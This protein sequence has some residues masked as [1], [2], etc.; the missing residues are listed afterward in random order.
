MLIISSSFR[1]KIT[2]PTKSQGGPDPIIRAR[3]DDNDGQTRS[4]PILSD[5]IFA[6]S[7]MSPI[8]AV[9]T[10][11]GE[12]E[13]P[14]EDKAQVEEQLKTPGTIRT[15]NGSVIRSSSHLVAIHTVIV[16]V[17]PS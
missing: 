11:S 6:I 15:I 17:I 2:V 14:D 4:C 13:M 7:L 8:R 12:E 16:T 3:Y 1:S 10:N 5:H 9:P